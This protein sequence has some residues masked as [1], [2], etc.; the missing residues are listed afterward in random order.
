MSVEEQQHQACQGPA[1]VEGSGLPAGK[2]PWERVKA[3]PSTMAAQR[4]NPRV[5]GALADRINLGAD[6]GTIA[7]GFK[8]RKGQSVV[9]SFYGIPDRCATEKVVDLFNWPGRVKTLC[10]VL[11][12]FSP[13][14][15]MNA[16]GTI[17]SIV[18]G[19]VEGAD[20]E[21]AYCDAIYENGMMGMKLMDGSESCVHRTELLGKADDFLVHVA[22]CLADLLNWERTNPWDQ[23]V[24]MQFMQ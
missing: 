4:I 17:S 24:L 3:R 13:H 23:S 8:F 20:G 12:I 7:N 19:I 14:M 21:I 22:D 1:L 5:P 16:D 11:R 6:P 9:L 10:G 2:H 15:T 18:E